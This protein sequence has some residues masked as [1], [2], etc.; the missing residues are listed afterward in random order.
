MRDIDQ[1]GEVLNAAVSTGANSISGTGFYVDDRKAATSAGRIEA[2]EDARTKAEELASAAGMTLGPVVAVSEGVAPITY[3]GSGMAGGGA[4]G[5]GGGAVPV[6]PGATTV[7][8]DVT[9]V[10]ALR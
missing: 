8:V 2:V 3:T 9:M 5:A 4:G 7:V 1:L 6:E 10:F